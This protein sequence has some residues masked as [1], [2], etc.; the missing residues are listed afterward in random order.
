[1]KKQF[2]LIELLI[3][4]AIIA[5]LAGMLLP[6]LGQ[7]KKA[8]ERAVCSSNQKQ[9]LAMH[10]SYSG[11]FKDYILPNQQRVRRAGIDTG[12]DR[13]FGAMYLMLKHSKIMG[14]GY[15]QNN[16]GFVWCPSFK[17]EK[18]KDGSALSYGYFMKRIPDSYFNSKYSDAYM[19]GN[20]YG[21]AMFT[22]YNP[23][24]SVTPGNPEKADAEWTYGGSGH[25]I[26]RYQDTD[27]LS[28]GLYMNRVRHPS[29]KAYLT[30]LVYISSALLHIPGGVTVGL[31]TAQQTDGLARSWSEDVAKGRHNQ[32]VNLGML[33]G[34]VENMPSLE[35][36]R[37][38]KDYQQSP[39]SA[40]R[41]KN[42]LGDYYD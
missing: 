28:A 39:N 33:D 23:L 37:I 8:V 36:A 32:S 31:S 21:I 10:A 18:G 7:A 20:E 3:V 30:E 4:I 38:K 15:W 35:V 12:N 11:D 5:I 14:D 27:R 25:H 34:H 9:I 22:S 42:I 24:S 2:T 17:Y 26:L 19:N 41:Q 6:A 40:T 13:K 1:M 16:P 29:R